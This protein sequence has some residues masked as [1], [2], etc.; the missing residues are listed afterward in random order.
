MSQ[1]GGIGRRLLG[2]GGFILALV[3]FNGLSYFF[4]W[5]WILY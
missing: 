5:G 2:V 3:V 1:G 4:N